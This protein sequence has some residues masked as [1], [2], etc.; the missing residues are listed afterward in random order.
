MLPAVL[1]SLILIFKVIVCLLQWLLHAWLP[2]C[3]L[4]CLVLTV[5]SEDREIRD[6]ISNQFIGFYDWLSQ[7]A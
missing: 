3:M 6:V 2:A 5:R 7:R 4:G 1:D